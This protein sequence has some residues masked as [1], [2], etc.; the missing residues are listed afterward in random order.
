MTATRPPRDASETLQL[1]SG[2]I[3]GPR[4]SKAGDV[5]W[6]ELLGPEHSVRRDLLYP[7]RL[8][9]PEQGRS[10]RSVGPSYSSKDY[11][12]FF[13]SFL[14]VFDR[15]LEGL[16]VDENSRNLARPS[17]LAKNFI[18]LWRRKGAEPNCSA[19]PPNV[20]S[21]WAG[22]VVKFAAGKRNSVDMSMTSRRTKK[23]LGPKPVLGQEGR[24]LARNVACDA[25]RLDFEIHNLLQFLTD[26]HELYFTSIRI[27]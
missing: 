15:T 20:R 7:Y 24:H 4:H 19:A 25:Q 9:G 1:V 16:N 10:Q 6:T 14:S 13:L 17:G 2:V 26:P 5:S 8:L 11:S 3:W 18:L 21:L 22:K 27:Y 23:S 12:F